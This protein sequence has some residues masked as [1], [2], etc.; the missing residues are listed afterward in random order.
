M[1]N[2]YVSYYI[3]MIYTDYQSTEVEGLSC[4]QQI[5]DKYVSL[6]PSNLTEVQRKICL[7]VASKGSIKQ[8]DLINFVNPESVEVIKNAIHGLIDSGL[9]VYNKKNNETF[10]SPSQN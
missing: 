3:C 5:V 9:I 2:I 1:Y 8:K 6:L 7:I 4:E 10:Y